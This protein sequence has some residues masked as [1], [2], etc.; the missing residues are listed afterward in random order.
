MIRT[1]G[2]N[3]EEEGHIRRLAQQRAGMHIL[4]LERMQ[5]P[6]ALVERA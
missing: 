5:R 4:R 1:E 2:R 3:I 6:E